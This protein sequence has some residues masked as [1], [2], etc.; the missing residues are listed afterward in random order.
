VY[1]RE[2]AFE[3]YLIAARASVEMAQSDLEAVAALQA[4]KAH[5]VR[6]KPIRHVPMPLSVQA[7]LPGIGDLHYANGYHAYWDQR[8]TV[9]LE[10]FS[11]AIE[12]NPYEPLYWYYRALTR[13]RLSQQA[14]ADEDAYAGAFWEH[15]RTLAERGQPIVISLS[16]ISQKLERVQGIDRLWLEAF[17]RSA[18]PR[19]VRSKDPRLSLEATEISQ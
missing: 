8:Y 17:R 6:I 5:F 10:S 19:P 3:N 4:L 2:R 16:Y 11:S 9:A 18:K 15:Q 13:K 12:D 7:K 1:N 14:N